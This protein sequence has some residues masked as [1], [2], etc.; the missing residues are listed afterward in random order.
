MEG[1]LTS[2]RQQV[3]RLEQLYASYSATAKE[4]ERQAVYK[5]FQHICDDFTIKFRSSYDA[6]S[7]HKP[8]DNALARH[9]V[10]YYS[11]H[12]QQIHCNFV[13]VFAK[14]KQLVQDS[15]RRQ[16]RLL[17]G[18][19]AAVD[20]E[21]LEQLESLQLS[22]VYQQVLASDHLHESIHTIQAQHNQ[23]AHLER[24][25][26]ELLELFKD[27]SLLVDVD[28]ERLEHIEAHVG[29]GRRSC[30]P[31]RA[32]FANGQSISTQQLA[33]TV[34]LLLLGRGAADHHSGAHF[35]DKTQRH[36]MIGVC[37]KPN[38]VVG[39]SVSGFA[40]KSLLSTLQR[41]VV[42]TI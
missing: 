25:L 36:V 24:A 4:D 38:L 17:L 22:Q 21:K 37:N 8:C 31:G 14:F 19:S 13:A 40:G 5:E 9:L 15:N 16:L 20:L 7:Q 33:Q 42:C 34:L 41:G 35:G 1:D 11:V 29:H 39:L 18:D 28:Q 3:A 32:G 30:D 23:M 27:L 26:L 2:F 6:L 10:K 12:L